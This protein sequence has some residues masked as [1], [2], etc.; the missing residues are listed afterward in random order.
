MTYGAFLDRE[1]PPTGGELAAALGD[2]RPLWDRIVARM[3]ATYGLEGER[4]FDGRDSGWVL[5]FRRSGKTLLVLLPEP[6]AARALV[7]LG[8][9]IAEAAAALPLEPEVRAAFDRAHAYPDGR[10]LRI[11]VGS[12]AVADDLLRLV[13]L[14]SPPPRRPRRAAAS[15]G[16]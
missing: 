4:L 14:K 7:V 13:E 2:R 12:E 11:E 3:E 1:H 8:P 10:W 15:A 9:S 5:R 6:G 16:G